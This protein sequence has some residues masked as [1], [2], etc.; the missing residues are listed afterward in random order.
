MRPLRLVLLAALALA[1][2]ACASTTPNTNPVGEVFPSVR[3]NSLSGK[4]YRLPE[5]VAGRPTVLLVAYVQDAQF[6]VDRWLLGLL[7]A[8]LNAQIY[9]VPT[10]EGF[11]PTV[12]SDVIDDGMRSGIPDEDWGAVVT[13]Y[14]D[15]DRIV[16]FTGNE[17]PRNCRAILLDADGK[18]VWFHDEGYSARLVLELEKKIAELDAAD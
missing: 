2:T 10:V 1:L 14:E 11:V 17:Q 18:V 9:E 15:G 16:A 13:V 4:P 6:D 8:R 3:G 5:D 12:L 7:Q